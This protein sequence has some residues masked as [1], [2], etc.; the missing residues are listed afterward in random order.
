MLLGY[1]AERRGEERWD[2]QKVVASDRQGAVPIDTVPARAKAARANR[3]RSWDGEAQGPSIAQSDG[4]ERGYRVS[5]WDSHD[6]QRLE[7][8]GVGC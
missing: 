1:E 6:G 5:T 7:A 3:H 8:E 4:A 2:T